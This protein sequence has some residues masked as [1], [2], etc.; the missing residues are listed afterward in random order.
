MKYLFT[1]AS[2]NDY[3]QEVFDKIISP[4]NKDYADY[5]GYR[6]VEIRKEHDPKPFRGNFTWNKFKVV[7][8]LL[9]TNVLKDGDIIANIDA[10]MFIVNQNSGIMPRTSASFAYSI[11]TGNTHCMGWFSIRVNSWSRKLIENILSEKRYQKLKDKVSVHERFGTTSSF[12][13]EFR[14]QAS[15]YSLAGIKRHSD[16]SFWDLPNNGFH[17]HTTE[18]TIYSLN[19]LN[20]HVDIYPT[21]FNVT[22]WPGESGCQF[23]INDYVTKEEV[24]IRHFAGGQDWNNIKNWC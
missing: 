13:Q 24:I 23:N 17:S 14:E 4:R 9:T 15:W 21:P 10:D 20:D 19:E 16:I 3:R 1:L 5:Q 22:E 2:Y 7:Q 11:D 6:Y 12:W 18:D 8:D